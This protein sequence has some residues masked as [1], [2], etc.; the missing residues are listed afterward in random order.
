ME[1]VF[2]NLLERY[3]IWRLSL[4]KD[5]RF[6]HYCLI[7]QFN[8]SKSIQI[9][10]IGYNYVIKKK[11]SDGIKLIPIHAE[12]DAINKL[13]NFNSSISSSRKVHLLVVRISENVK[14][15]KVYNSKP[16]SNCISLM[17][18]KIEKKGYNLKNIYY[19]FES[20]DIKSSIIKK[21]FQELY[22]D[23][24]KH[25]TVYYKHLN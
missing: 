2:L 1:N 11:N 5:E 17:H 8:N 6:L 7:F 20:F 22:S 4:N 13:Q 24:H 23:P 10:S 25:I 3:R 19:S 15:D 16:C 14:N 12:E 21:K 18:D 9:L